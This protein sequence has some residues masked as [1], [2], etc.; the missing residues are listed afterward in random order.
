MITVQHKGSTCLGRPYLPDYFDR[1]PKERLLELAVKIAKSVTIDL[2]AL[3]AKL[4]LSDSKMQ[5]SLRELGAPSKFTIK[6]PIVTQ[7]TI[8]E[9]FAIHVEFI[10]EVH[11]NAFL[12]NADEHPYTHLMNFDTLCGTFNKKDVS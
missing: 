10:C 6:S 3:F 12:G 4:T 9:D 8:A 7:T 11:N 5:K 2:N 1:S